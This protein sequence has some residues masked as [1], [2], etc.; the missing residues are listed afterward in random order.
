MHNIIQ[1]PNKL[2]HFIQDQMIPGLNLQRN[3]LNKDQFAAVVLSDKDLDHIDQLRL[4]SKGKF[5][6]VS[7]SH[8]HNGTLQ[9]QIMV[10][11]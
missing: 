6:F 7:L 10:N 3:D 8:K 2:K 9:M 11:W 5:Y 1:A 4:T